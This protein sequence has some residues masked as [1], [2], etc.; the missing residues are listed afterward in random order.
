MSEPVTLTDAKIAGLRPPERGRVEIIDKVVPGLRVRIGPSG[1]VSFIVRKRVGGSIKNVTLGRYGPR[2]TLADAR[3]SARTAL[4][5]LTAGK[6]VVP[7]KRD[8][9]TI[10]SLWA[11]Y[12][13]TKAKLRSHHEIIRI[14]EKH[15]LPEL[16]DRMA[17]AVTRG[18]VTRFIDGIKAPVMARL[19]HA[20][21]SAFYT[22]ALPRLDKLDS[23]PCRDAGRPS[24][25]K[26]RDRVLTETEL[27]TLWRV[28]DAQA[29]PWRSAVHLIILTG[30]RK[31]EVFEARR[32]E[33]DLGAGVWTIPAERAKNEETHI[34]PLSASAGVVLE[35]I[36]EIEG[37][38]MLFPAKG[39]P[40]KPASG[41]GKAVERMRAGLRAELGDDVP[42]WSLHDIRRTVATGLQR[43]G[44]RF[45]VT[46]AV[47]NHVSGSKGGIAG[48]YQRHN[49][50]DEKRAA[51]DAWAAEL[52]RILQGA[53]ADNVVKLRV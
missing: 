13:L 38:K 4:S 40:D 36:A 34:V 35:G 9:L 45:E 24:K 49:W 7:A 28:A 20:Q 19:V 50:A 47:L 2:F 51:L 6:K 18:E 10:K 37:S 23:N 15:V 29:E 33:F 42:Q 46:E 30:Q 39:N 52:Q 26:A 12:V 22:W 43:L 8:S 11:E 16:G 27:A 44:I 25:P 41:I 53:K 17:D 5:D 14:G 31:S 3:K 48:V 32:G 1:M 21:L